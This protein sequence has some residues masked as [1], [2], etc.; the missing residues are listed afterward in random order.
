MVLKLSLILTERRGAYFI[1]YWGTDLKTNHKAYAQGQVVEA[2]VT[3]GHV[4]HV[5]E[6]YGES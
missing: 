1:D 4:V 2:C 3:D 5:F 6:Y